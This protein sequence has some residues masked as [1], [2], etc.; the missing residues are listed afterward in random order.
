MPKVKKIIKSGLGKPLPLDELTIQREVDGSKHWSSASVF[1]LGGV[2]KCADGK[3]RFHIR[4][5]SHVDGDLG[6]ELRKF[7]GKYSGFRFKFFRST[8]NAFDK[9]CKIYHDFKPIEN[10]KHPVKPKNTKFLCS[11]VDCISS[12]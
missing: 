11:V 7:I 8:R 2:R 9:E 10:I 1:V 3:L 6:V 5:V 4:K 12:D